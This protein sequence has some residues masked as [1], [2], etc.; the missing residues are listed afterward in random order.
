[1]S[2]I[3][4][5]INDD[6]DGEANSVANDPREVSNQIYDKE[7]VKK[8]PQDPVI[9]EDHLGDIKARTAR[10]KTEQGTMLRK[11]HVPTH[12]HEQLEKRVLKDVSARVVGP[13]FNLGRPLKPVDEIQ[14]DVSHAHHESSKAYDEI[15]EQE[16]GTPQEP[17]LITSNNPGGQTMRRQHKEPFTLEERLARLKTEQA[18]MLRAKHVPNRLQPYL[19]N[20]VL[21]DTTRGHAVGFEYNF[22]HAG[23]KMDVVEAEPSKAL[24]VSSNK[25]DKIYENTKMTE[26]RAEIY[27]ERAGTIKDRHNSIKN[28]AGRSL[29]QKHLPD[30]LK[31]VSLRDLPGQRTVG[32]EYNMYGDAARREQ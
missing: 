15:Y 17:E 27:E 21:V 18:T 29:R 8:T 20:K 32:F 30:R 14:G 2:F 13:E 11:K 31:D 7:P 23:G 9:E 16:R 3:R 26:K 5:H 4:E 6:A 25:Y 24:L 28:N 19:K 10:L 12:L 1:M 22:R